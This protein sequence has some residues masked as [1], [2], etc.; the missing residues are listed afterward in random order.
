M[1]RHLPSRA[2][3]NPFPI[4]LDQ[5]SNL[6]CLCAVIFVYDMLDGSSRLAHDL[7]FQAWRKPP[8][9]ALVALVVIY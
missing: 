1:L 3:G 5:A 4:L 6:D 2:F 7:G 9:R 8:R